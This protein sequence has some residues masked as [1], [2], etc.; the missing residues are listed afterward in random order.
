[1]LSA[2][3]CV[4][5]IGGEGPGEDAGTTGTAA[6][7]L[8]VARIRLLNARE[9]RQTVRDLLGVEVSEALSHADAGTGYDTGAEGKVD[10]NLFFA[11]VEEAERVAEAYLDGPISDDFPCYDDDASAQTCLET[12]VD[13]L[14]ARAYRRPLTDDQKTGLMMLHED[15][16]ATSDDERLAMM[17]IVQRLLSSVHFLYRT[18]LGVRDG[19]VSVLDP[20]ERASLMS[21]TLTGTMPDAKLFAAAKA[22]ELEGEGIRTHARRL[23]GTDAGKAQMVRFVIQWLRLQPLDEMARN[24]DDFPKLDDPN[25]GRSLRTELAEY[26]THTLFEE[27][28]SVADLL[29]GRITYGDAAVAD[30]YGVTLD[31]EADEAQPFAL[32]DERRGILSLASTMSVHASVAEL[33]KDR[34]V[35]RGLLI[36]NQLLCEEV[37]L[38]AGVDFLA[39]A[40]EAEVESFDELTT[41][42]QFESIMNQ[43]QACIDCHAQFMPFGFLFGN[44]D[45]LGR[46]QTEK[47]DRPIDTVVEEIPVANV[48][49]S[50]DDHLAL[51]DM[52]SDS[53]VVSKCFSQNLVAFVV[54]TA[55]KETLRAINDELLEQVDGDRPVVDLLEEVLATPELYERRWVSAD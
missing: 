40:E 42:E 48:P 12:I 9:Y 6:E 32:P 19:P 20:Y 49:S 30:L 53:P 27:E 51:I 11:F 28:G 14:G 47:G 3:A 52:L 34:P 55:D 10:E 4:G 31:G 26:V 5:N 46:Y 25:L 2:A 37:G 45:A 22:G 18:E 16:L 24:P 1:M 13:A 21:Y 41:R 7:A 8:D 38:P 29:N 39:A 43:D 50:F 17:S 54:G 35:I 15:V 36:K 23:L 33:E 44:F